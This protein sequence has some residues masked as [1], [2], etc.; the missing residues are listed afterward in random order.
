MYEDDFLEA[1]YEDN[2]GG[3]Y[4]ALT[5]EFDDW[6]DED[7]EEE[8]YFDDNSDGFGNHFGNADVFGEGY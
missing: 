3:Y 5:D 6:S 8:D 4:D 1:Q 2:N 7:I